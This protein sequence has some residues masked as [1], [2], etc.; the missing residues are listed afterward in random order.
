MSGVVGGSDELTRFDLGVEGGRRFQLETHTLVALSERLEGLRPVSPATR[1]HL[2]RVEVLEQGA[3]LG[4]QLLVPLDQLRG[5]GH[6][7]DVQLHGYLHRHPDIG[8]PSPYTPHTPT[9]AAEAGRY[10]DGTLHAVP[11]Q[12]YHLGQQLLRNVLRLVAK[13]EDG[14]HGEGLGEVEHDLRR[15]EEDGEGIGREGDRAVRV[16]HLA[17]LVGEAVHLEGLLAE[18]TH[19][20][21]CLVHNEE[22]VLLHDG[23]RVAGLV[24]ADGP[25]QPG[26]RVSR[27]E[28]PDASKH[29][30]LPPVRSRFAAGGVQGRSVHDPALDRRVER[31][32]ILGPFAVLDVD[33]FRPLDKVEVVDVPRGDHV[34][35]CGPAVAPHHLHTR[36]EGLLVVL[37]KL[38]Q[39]DRLLRVQGGKRRCGAGAVRGVEGGRE[40]Q[41][42]VGLG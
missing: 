26:E 24:G 37:H 13:V 2:G 15:V 35:L 20:A 18:A 38:G 8:Y 23:A 39:G 27:H 10:D 11:H 21:R 42:R 14:L 36:R 3:R 17:L 40:D 6:H 32:G 4:A 7:L 30:R 29:A 5:Y 9:T 28:L 31:D 22:L 19:L 34:P 33:H 12:G 1:P 16:E 25:H 41:A